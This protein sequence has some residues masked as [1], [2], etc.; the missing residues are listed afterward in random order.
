MVT[1]KLRKMT[2]PL[3][4][5]T[6]WIAFWS[7]SPL[8]QYFIPYCP[9]EPRFF[10]F[11]FMFTKPWAVQTSCC[12]PVKLSFLPQNFRRLYI[13]SNNCSF[14]FCVLK[15][16][17][18]GSSTPWR[19]SHALQ[20]L[21]PQNPR[22]ARGHECQTKWFGVL[23]CVYSITWFAF[24]IWSLVENQLPKPACFLRRQKHNAT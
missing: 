21:L 18:A 17:A 6:Q 11:F 7:S 4:I 9:G 3:S 16:S 10:F 15:N 20:L 8:Y 23:I 13:R 22:L 2:N 19:R 5:V 14:Y 12:R 1:V 24:L